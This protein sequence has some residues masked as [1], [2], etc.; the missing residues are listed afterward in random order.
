MEELRFDG[1]TAIVTGAG[2]NPSLGRAHALLLAA[3]GANVVVNDI[4]SDPEMR[5]YP[6]TASAETVAEEIRAA[7]GKAVADTHSVA[8][9][10]GAEAI[11]QTALDAFGG[12][13]ILVNNAA[14][15]IGAPF[16]EMTPHDFQRHIDVNLMGTVWTCRAAWPHMKQQGYGRIVNTTSSSMTGFANQSAYCTSKGAVWSLTRSLASEGAAYGIQVNAISPGAFTRLVTSMLEQ[17]SPLLQHSRENLPPEL[18]SPALAWLCHDQCNVTGECIDSVGGEVQRTFIRRTKGFSDREVTI[19]T[20][21]ERWD[22][23]IAEADSE[24]IGIGDMDTSGWK[25]RPYSG[26]S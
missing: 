25:I 24:V 26:G 3:R 16:D 4:G 12:L 5:N 22:E 15:S 14:I 10:E 21:A 11:V 19:E 20:V 1:R 23:V 2:G 8:T 6:G 9:V 13:D 18:S 17:D 7:G